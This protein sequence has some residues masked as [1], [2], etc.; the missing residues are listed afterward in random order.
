MFTQPIPAPPPDATNSV[1]SEAA[2]TFL[3]AADRL[4]ALIAAASPFPWIAHPDGLVWPARI[5]DPVCAAALPE[6]AQLI[7]TLAAAVSALAVMLRDEARV[8][9]VVG[10]HH[11]LSLDVARAVLGG[12]R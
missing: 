4:D 2:A 12:A 10:D 9:Q 5:G 6:D 7:A 8:A 1:P 3:A 11:G